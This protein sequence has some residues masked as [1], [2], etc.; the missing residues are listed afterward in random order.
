MLQIIIIIITCD[1]EV[2]VKN[3][4]YNFSTCSMNILFKIGVTKAWVYILQHF[5]ICKCLLDI[6]T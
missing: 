5:F 6:Q 1:M 3:T 2:H 4:L